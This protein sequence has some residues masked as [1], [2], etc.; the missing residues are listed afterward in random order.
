MQIKNGYGNATTN[1]SQ[2]SSLQR[3]KN[4]SGPLNENKH[5]FGNIKLNLG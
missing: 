5:S 2:T 4:T 3:K 1:W